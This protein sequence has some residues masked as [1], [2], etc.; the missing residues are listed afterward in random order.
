MREWVEVPAAHAA[1]WP[2]LAREALHY[3]TA[4]L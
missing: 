1:R 2:A 4:T 3:L